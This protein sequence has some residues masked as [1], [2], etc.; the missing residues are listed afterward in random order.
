MPEIQAPCV[1]SYIGRFVIFHFNDVLT[2]TTTTMM[3]IWENGVH[4][5]VRCLVMYANVPMSQILRNKID[6]HNVLM[7]RNLVLIN[8]LDS[9][10]QTCDI[11]N[12]GKQ[13][14]SNKLSKKKV[15]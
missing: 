14:V 3:V 9:V 4:V 10:R 1:D 8:R 13:I 7:I 15:E 12:N 11:N 2:S 6:D 5:Y